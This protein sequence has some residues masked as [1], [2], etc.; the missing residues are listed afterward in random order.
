VIARI[1]HGRTTRENADAYEALLREEV[2]PGI[3]RIDGYRGAYLLRT[4]VDA[5]AGVEF[6]TVTLWETIEAIRAFA[7]DDYERAV[8]PPQARELLERFD[9]R[10]RH[11]EVRAEP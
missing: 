4:D 8:V 1:W 9:E 10:T 5:G 2:F 6:V 3:H 11:Y 7:G